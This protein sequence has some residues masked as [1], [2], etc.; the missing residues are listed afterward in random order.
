MPTR[1]LIVARIWDDLHDDDDD[2]ER[3]Q[4][5][6]E[7]TASSGP[8]D[9]D[10]RSWSIY[11]SK[12]TEKGTVKSV[13]PQVKLTVEQETPPA[14]RLTPK[15]FNPYLHGFKALGIATA[16]VSIAAVCT[17]QVTSWY[18]DVNTVPFLVRET[19]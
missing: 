11:C 9:G 2:D 6:A 15:P 3:G 16:L 12:T 4:Q 18:L 8:I 19:I 1:F 13:P 17:V 5:E 10:I 14:V 7:W